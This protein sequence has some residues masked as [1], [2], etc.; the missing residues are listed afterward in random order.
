MQLLRP[1]SARDYLGQQTPQLYS[2]ILKDHV[3]LQIKLALA[4]GKAS[5]LTPVQF[6]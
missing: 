1:C 3:M 2:A 6:L 5:I 4:T